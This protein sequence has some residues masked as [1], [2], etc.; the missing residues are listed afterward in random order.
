MMENVKLNLLRACVISLF[1]L[2]M[3]PEASSLLGILG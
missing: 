2:H 3:R 1:V